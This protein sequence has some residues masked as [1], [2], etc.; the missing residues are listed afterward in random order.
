VGDYEAGG[1][2]L[3]Q[4]LHFNGTKWA[5]APTP[6]PGGTASGDSNRLF[7]IVCPGASN[8][9]AAGD[10]GS[11]SANVNLNQLLRW[12]GSKW[13][14]AKPLPQPAGTA[15][16]AFQQLNSVRC[17]STSSC[18]AVGTANTATDAGLFENEALRWNGTTWSPTTIPSPG[19]TADGDF[20]SL[21]SLA[22]TSATNC[23]A[24]GVDGSNL[25]GTSLNQMMHW[26]GTAWTQDIF[27][28]QPA[29][30]VPGSFN[31][32]KGITCRTP[33]DCWAVG[34]FLGN[35]ALLNEAIHF[36][37][38]SWSPFPP[39]N[40]DGTSAR[41]VN[42]LQMVRCAAKSDCW[43]VGAVSSVQ[44]NQLLHWN[45]TQWLAG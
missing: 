21:S 4:A 34:D 44:A 6:E 23:W 16:A 39:P 5:A 35:G 24:D 8:C 18:L 41:S 20:S 15:A 42:A 36:D 30:T 27:I 17:T 45:G 12:N 11:G 13:T 26:D 2:N 3:N 40:P 28:D 14:L 22:C 38:S 9:W 33:S 32:L 37:G 43:A 7:D 31:A 29:G 1:A 10:Y 25:T 19:G